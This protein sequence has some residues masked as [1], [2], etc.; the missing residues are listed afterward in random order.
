MESADH[1]APTG[2]PEPEAGHPFGP[3]PA[4]E[5]GP[6]AVSDPGPETVPPPAAV[7]DPVG[8]GLTPAPAG[9]PTAGAAGTDDEGGD[10]PDEVSS[11][12]GSPGPAPPGPENDDVDPD[13]EEAP[14]P[15]V[16]AVVVTHDPGPD[17]EVA[18]AQLAA[19]DYP[20]L[21]ILVVDSGSN[22][23][24]TARIAEV[25][26]NAFV[27][28]LEQNVGFAVAANETLRAVQGA[29]FLLLCHDDI[30]PES[31]C[32]RILVEEAYRSNAAIVGPKLVD[33]AEPNVLL[34]VGQSI[35]RFG[36]PYSGLEPDELD[37][38]QHD[39]VRDVFFVTDAAML[40]RSDLFT[41]LEGFDPAT[42][43]GGED[44]DLCWRAR[45]MGAR[46]MVVPDA[47]VRHRQQGAESATAGTASA[48]IPTRNRLRAL[49]KAYSTW[50][51]VR[52]VP[53]ALL[54]NVVE[55]ILLFASR[56]GA[57]ARATLGA[58]WWNLR[59]LSTIREDRRSVQ[60]KRRIPDSEL[61]YLQTRGSARFRNVV[62]SRRA[63]SRAHDRPGNRTFV[64]TA[65]AELRTRTGIGWIV[66]ILL[67]LFGARDLVTGSVS[68][69]G[70]F[71]SWPGVSGLFDTFSGSWRY[72][73]LGSPSPAAPVFA[74]MGGLSTLLFGAVGMAKTSL[75]VLSLP[76]GALG[77]SR[78]A[79]R[80]EGGATGALAAA[81]AYLVAPVGRNSIAHGSFG[82][83]ALYAFAPWLLV[84][85][86]EGAA[87][88][89]PSSRSRR[90]RVVGLAALVAFVSAWYLPTLL[91][92]P[93]VALVW[94]VM[95][96]PGDDVKAGRLAST[97]GISSLVAVVLLL[98]WPL[99]FVSGAGRLAAFGFIDRRSMDLADVLKLGTG[100][101]GTGW[102]GWAFLIA[103]ILPVLIATGGRLVGTARAWQLALLGFALAWIPGRFFPGTSWLTPDATL[104]LAALGL[105]VAIGLGCSALLADVHRF[106]FGGRQVAAVV[107]AMAFVAPVFGATVAT[108]DGRWDQPGSDW[109]STLSWM[110]DKAKTGD[111]R[112]LWVG[113][114]SV[115]PLDAALGPDR[116]SFALSADGAPDVAD[117]WAPPIGDAH[118]VADSLQIA[119]AGRTQY[120]GRLLAPAG[121]RYLALVDRPAPESG[122]RVPVPATVRR[123]LEQQLDLVAR[124]MPDGMTL[125]ENRSYIAT[126]AITKDADAALA[127]QDTNAPA[128]AGAFLNPNA[129]TPLPGGGSP[130]AATGP[131]TVVWS[132]SADPNWRATADGRALGRVTTFGWG[133]GFVMPRTGRVAVSYDGGPLRAFAI[134]I[135]VVLWIVA[136]LIVLA[137]W[138]ATR[139]AAKAAAKDAAAMSPSTSGA[140]S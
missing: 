76:F 11:G 48:A 29:T 2:A 3:A 30:A 128:T 55:S 123:A 23:D 12:T 65:S 106:H 74:V 18:L 46:V 42:F 45:L 90:A 8:P 22:H 77:A 67:A 97:A 41:E 86:L 26:P 70:S 43:P 63:E 28:R 107:C 80:F 133:N 105:S 121:V 62:A 59:H 75:I 135:D 102:T 49:F 140:S 57:R 6:G 60:A 84:V 127:V 54:L 33:Y 110:P 15:P 87:R 99:Q 111:F 13:L 83:L 5:S 113:D 7:E 116:L 95:P 120:L 132:Q 52:V 47:R 25:A 112:L 51:L 71:T 24:P 104:V 64:S 119:L 94:A 136:L 40:V 82:A 14:A 131:G 134:G 10:G 20:A 38:E 36:E 114:P 44:L 16:V 1:P 31:D 56:R 61:R 129:F 91:F 58:W 138:R 103:A 98:P 93:A 27:K 72:A 39:S 68:G 124:Q 50:T 139:R 73:A 117:S 53:I 101:A 108:L 9:D 66:L 85:W 109:A 115:L 79:R 137:P 21:S 118:W 88:V 4:H 89:R 34:D 125:Y 126:R 37:Q 92:L 100:P 130:S 96:V 35:D 78:L 122:A 69:V 81:V 32:V 17:F 19:Q